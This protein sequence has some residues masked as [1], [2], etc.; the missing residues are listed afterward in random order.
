MWAIR[1]EKESKMTAAIHL[2]PL[3]KTVV[4]IGMEKL[5]LRALEVIPCLISKNCPIVRNSSH[6]SKNL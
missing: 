5:Q 4:L 3:V 2:E 6:K 1:G